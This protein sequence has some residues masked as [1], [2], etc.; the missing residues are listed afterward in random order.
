MAI[1]LIELD[2]TE[3]DTIEAFEYFLQ[4]ARDHKMAGALVAIS[5]RNKR[6]HNHMFAVT[7]RLASDAT[8]A[9]GLAGMLHLQMVQSALEND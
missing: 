1:K 6:K 3:H 4:M 8:E 2:F 7:G 9:A 5:L